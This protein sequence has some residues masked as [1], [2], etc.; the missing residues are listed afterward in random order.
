M[1]TENTQLDV[2][3]LDEHNRLS[4]MET[5]YEPEPM[6]RID[7]KF[8]Y[9]N[10]TNC[11]DKITT[12]HIELSEPESEP[13]NVRIIR[14]DV[15]LKIIKQNQITTDN[16]KFYLQ[17][18]MWYNVALKP[19]NIQKS[20]YSE[21]STDTFTPFFKRIHIVQLEDIILQPSIFIFHSLNCLY[22]IYQERKTELV[23]NH[24]QL[25]SILKTSKNRDIDSPPEPKQ[26]KKVHI[27][28]TS[29][30]KSKKNEKLI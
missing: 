13:L 28:S 25:K 10:N 19:E 12:D 2:S 23:N 29:L 30:R 5:N 24:R 16:T 22:F 18:I 6:S 4:D 21:N 7:I 1:T 11:I 14:K 26:T 3:W 15:I 17:D 8:I 27:D 20:I 9:I